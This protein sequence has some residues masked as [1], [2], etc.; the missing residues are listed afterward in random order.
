[1]TPLSVEVAAVVSD[2]FEMLV[3]ADVTIEEA[4]DVAR[5]V[6]AQYRKHGLIPG[7]ANR[8]CVLGGKGYRPGPSIPRLYK[9]QPREG[10]FWQLLTCGIEPH[11]GRGF[12]DLALGPVREGF[13]CPACRAEIEPF[14][15]AFGDELARAIA[16][17]LDQSGPALVRCPKCEE[18]SLITQWQCKP[19]LGFGNLSFRFWNWPP[20]ASSSW[21]IDIVALTRE[22]SRHT[23]VS[24]HGHL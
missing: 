7:K 2:N 4:K 5:A 18:R 11:V 3:D 15:G 1:M 14:E 6:L 20:L 16:E 12:N 13:S 9:R 17:W 23:I 22:A 21:K 24:T 10:R 8:E 19:P